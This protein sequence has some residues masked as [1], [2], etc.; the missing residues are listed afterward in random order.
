MGITRIL[1]TVSKTDIA[2]AYATGGENALP[3]SLPGGNW[4]MPLVRFGGAQAASPSFR[5]GKGVEERLQEFCPPQTPKENI[6]K[7]I[8]KGELP[9][10]LIAESDLTDG[11][12]ADMLVDLRKWGFDQIR[13]TR[14]EVLLTDYYNREYCYDGLAIVS[15][16]GKDIAVSLFRRSDPSQLIRKVFEGRAAD[17]RVESVAMKIWDQVKDRTLDLRYETER[18][19]LLY[20]AEKILRENPKEKNDNIRLSDNDSYHYF[21][22]NKMLNDLPVTEESLESIFTNYLQENGMAD[23]GNAAVILR[24]QAIGNHYIA[25]STTRYFASKEQDTGSLRDAIARTIANMDLEKI[26]DSIDQSFADK[27]PQGHGPGGVTP[28]P[29]E[30]KTDPKKVKPVERPVDPPVR[31]FIPV[32]ITARIDS[33]RVGFLKRK[34]VLHITIDLELGTSLPWD[35]V[36]CVQADPLVTIEERNVVRTYEKGKRGPFSL[37]LDLPLAQCPKA[38]KLRVYFKPDPNEPIGINNAYVQDPVTVD[39]D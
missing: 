36:L 32:N 23:R 7:S 19:A 17:I 3:V 2:M 34:S 15:S 11:N 35:S 5:I 6:V 13:Y 12:V 18:N 9:I 10:V 28:K 33:V 24:N 4:P 1:I 25:D 14:P 38:K 16:N 22:T 29:G 21:L 39:V 31:E 27:I 8:S 37:D 26:G 30:D 20:E